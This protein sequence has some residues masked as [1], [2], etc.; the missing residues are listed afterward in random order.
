MISSNEDIS[1]EAMA[2]FLPVEVLLLRYVFISAM[3]PIT[4]EAIIRGVEITAMTK[5][6]AGGSAPAIKKGSK[7]IITNMGSETHRSEFFASRN[8]P[9][10]GF[11]VG[12]EFSLP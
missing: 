2:N 4:G 6:T 8:V 10:F 3:M 11:C 9:G 12:V 5:S 1:I 7:S